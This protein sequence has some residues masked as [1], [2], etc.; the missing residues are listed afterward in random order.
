MPSTIKSRRVLRRHILTD[1]ANARDN[2]GDWMAALEFSAED[3]ASA[4]Y[5]ELSAEILEALADA[6]DNRGDWL[7]A[8]ESVADELA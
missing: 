3:L 7:V 4:G 5:P 6:R 8:I 2:R 1:L